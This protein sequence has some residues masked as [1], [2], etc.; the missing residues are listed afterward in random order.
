MPIDKDEILDELWRKHEI[1]YDAL[2]EL[3][4]R[5]APVDRPDYEGQMLNAEL[6]IARIEAVYD[7]IDNDKQ[8]A[9]P[10]EQQTQALAEATGKLEV[11]VGRNKALGTLIGATTTLVKTWPVSKG[12]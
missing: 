3:N 1:L 6:E 12:G 9:F 4:D 10:T 8:I 5:L 2:Q 7:M 11:M